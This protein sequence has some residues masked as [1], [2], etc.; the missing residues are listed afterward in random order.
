MCSAKL[1]SGWNIS[2]QGLSII[3]QNNVITD[4]N[5]L[6][7]NA[8]NADL[9]EIGSP[10][11]NKESNKNQIPELVLQIQKIRNVAAPKAN[12]ESN[13]APRMLKL[14]LT[15]GETFVQAIETSNIPSISREKTP[16]GSKLLLKNV[17]I[18]NGF[19]CL[20]QSNTKLLGGNVPHL[21]E[22]WEVAK[23]VQH[24]NRITAS[25]D[26]PP[27]WVNFGFKISNTG[28]ERKV[29]DNGK[30]K[31]Q[32]KENTEFE[33]LRKDAIAEVATGAVKKVFASGAKLVHTAPRV[34]TYK[35][36]NE[37]GKHSNRNRKEPKSPK[38]SISQKPS[39]KVSLFD[40]LENKLQIANGSGNVKPKQEEISEKYSQ[41]TVTEDKKNYYSSY[42]KDSIPKKDYGYNDKRS[43]SEF[44][45]NH[46]Y[47][48]WSNC[49][50][51]KQP[52]FRRD[53]ESNKKEY[54]NRDHQSYEQIKVHKESAK[55]YDNK[56]SNR[57]NTRESLIKNNSST[58]HVNDM[59]ST[60]IS[61]DHI[62]NQTNKNSS[63][64]SKNNK[65]CKRNE[66]EKM[67]DN[68]HYR[69]PNP[70]NVEQSKS[71]SIVEQSKSSSNVEQSKS[72]SNVEQS[73]SGSNVNELAEHVAK[74]SVGGEFAS[75]SLRQHLNL[76][77][78]KSN[79][80]K[81]NRES[82]RSNNGI[83]GN[84]C[85]AKYWED[86]KFYPAII[87]AYTENT[88][89]VQFKGYGNFEEVLKSD[90]MPLDEE[91]EEKKKYHKGSLEFRRN[92]KK[93]EYS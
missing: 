35:G 51:Q 45:Y 42:H 1:A 9:K 67:H 36:R 22:K 69:A 55:G 19:L 25:I 2:Q 93:F 11:L 48:N 91:K 47:N 41:K 18:V 81:S 32:P 6:L 62:E 20:N 13:A 52:S 58:K 73:K 89:V 12:E 26:G 75:R 46:E 39:D 61:L 33:N 49:N 17:K 43:S 24:H 34:D 7:K 92:P 28:D 86:N 90:C 40:F 37:G 65:V 53:Q 60:K 85:L 29:T 31:E 3:S 56:Y 54:K 44:H 14:T 74:M 80:T 79:V 66:E 16:P 21:F 63:N 15:D 83:V 76:Q 64:V 50:I 71:S 23:S 70:N 82:I 87:T 4:Q 27:A 72:T 30:T 84:E 88:Y 77:G 59:Q 78:K 8:L 68:W 10:V 5:I 57:Y 38:E